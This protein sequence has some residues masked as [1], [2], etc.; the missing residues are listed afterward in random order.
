MIRYGSLAN[1]I[2]DVLAAPDLTNSAA[3]SSSVKARTTLL[4][5]SHDEDDLITS[6]G[7]ERC[8]GLS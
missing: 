5:Q 3:T 7:D 2:L 8:L 1:P 6:N 4:F